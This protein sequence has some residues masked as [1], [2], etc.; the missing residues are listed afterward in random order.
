MPLLILLE[1]SWRF[2]LC[3]LLLLLLRKTGLIT[4]P[5]RSLQKESRMRCFLSFVTASLSLGLS[6]NIYAA[7]SIEC[8]GTVTFKQ[9]TMEGRG[10]VVITQAA[11]STWYLDLGDS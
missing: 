8:E 9:G 11:D 4:I 10:K 3:P 2:V 7:R 1:S 5:R 6:T